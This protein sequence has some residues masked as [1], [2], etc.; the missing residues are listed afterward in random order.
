MF[1]KESFLQQVLIKDSHDRHKENENMKRESETRLLKP[2]SKKPQG[3]PETGAASSIT[4]INVAPPIVL[5][6]TSATRKGKKI[7]LHLLQPPALWY[8]VKAFSIHYRVW[9][10]GWLGLLWI[11]CNTFFISLMSEGPVSPT[12]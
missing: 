3:I 5:V 10:E 2:C 7:K 11:L 8:Y 12:A 1:L 6:Q 9:F 4:R